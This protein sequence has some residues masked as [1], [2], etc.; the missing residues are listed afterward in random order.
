MAINRKKANDTLK[1][2]FVERADDTLLTLDKIEDSYRKDISTAYIE[3]LGG[4]V[5]YRP[6]GADVTI[7][8]LEE[9]ISRAAQVRAM[10][11]FLSE[12]LCD[13]EGNEFIS[14]ERAVKLPLEIIDNIVTS[15]AIVRK[16]S[17]KDSGKNAS[18]R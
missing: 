2:A 9:G 14:Y 12:S 18:R 4:S 3:E 13:A 10:A 5:H 11:R 17:A 16:K 15:L 6:V 7:A 8:F 1:T